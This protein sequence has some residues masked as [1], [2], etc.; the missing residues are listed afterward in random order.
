MKYLPLNKKQQAINHCFCLCYLH[1]FI[2]QTPVPSK[3]FPSYS[4]TQYHIDIYHIYYRTDYAINLSC[5]KYDVV[6]SIN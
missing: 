5:I 4:E 3:G 1:L 2:T 6:S